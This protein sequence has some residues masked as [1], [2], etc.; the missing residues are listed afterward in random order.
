M[1]AGSGGGGVGGGV[2]DVRLSVRRPPVRPSA[3]PSV[4][5]SV[6]PSASGVFRP[7]V[8][9]G[10]RKVNIRTI[11]RWHSLGGDPGFDFVHLSWYFLSWYFWFGRLKRISAQDEDVQRDDPLSRK[12]GPI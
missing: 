1:L 12:S 10:T 9:D 3:R 11:V 2:P 4:G 6:G 5:P 7:P 8:P